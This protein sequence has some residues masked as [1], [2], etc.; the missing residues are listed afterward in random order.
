MIILRD[1]TAAFT[2]VARFPLHSSCTGFY[3]VGLPGSN[4]HGWVAPNL[5]L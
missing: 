1:I 4:L 2:P 5:G 3:G